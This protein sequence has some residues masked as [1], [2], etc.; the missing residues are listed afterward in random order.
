MK[1]GCLARTLTSSLL[2]MYL[3]SEV[4]KDL[5][6]KQFYRIFKTNCPFA[7]KHSKVSD[8]CDH[9]WLYKTP[10]LPGISKRL[11]AGKA[12]LC[13]MMP[14]YFASFREPWDAIEN[15]PLP[16]LEAFVSFLRTHADRCARAREPL[17][18]RVRGQLHELEAKLQHGL[19]HELAVAKAYEWHTQTAERQ[20]DAFAKQ[21][22]N[23]PQGECMFL[24]DYKQK[25]S[26]PQA[27]TELGSMWYGQDRMELTIFGCYLSINLTGII[28]RYKV[29]FISEIIE[30]T[31]LMSC[32]L[33]NKIIELFPAIKS[34]QR[35]TLWSDVGPHFRAYS[36][37][38]H[39]QREIFPVLAGTLRVCYYGEKHGKGLIDSMFGIFES[40]IN[41]FLKVPQRLITTTDELMQVCSNAAGAMNQKNPQSSEFATWQVVRYESELKPQHSWQLE[42]VNFS[43][44]KTYCVQFETP[45]PNS[46][47]EKPRL[48]NFVFADLT[49]TCVQLHYPGTSPS[50][51]DDRTWRRGYFSSQKWNIKKPKL[52][53]KDS[54]MLKFEHHTSLGISGYHSQTP[55]EKQMASRTRRLFLRRE[56]YKANQA[57]E[58]SSDDDGTSSSSSSDSSSSSPKEGEWVQNR[59]S[60]RDR[61]CQCASIFS[62][63]ITRINQL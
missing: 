14:N 35:V 6:W 52:G 3:S 26:L 55:W 4:K 44:T 13:N 22:Q 1:Q 36:V 38:A 23:L 18:A 50:Y 54:R 61:V 8:Y 11:K 49:N 16:M 56:R 41:A 12:A 34:C 28:Q 32:M 63:V 7:L 19:K 21:N 46:D 62:Q 48:R 10:I 40:W 58:S 43:I 53:E 37:L 25:Y 30:N 33:F 57:V 29:I 24:V 5:A 9:C 31:G 27:S 59:C 60:W 51:I 42:D 20:K 17:G 15:K 45:G 39:L 47:R 2:S